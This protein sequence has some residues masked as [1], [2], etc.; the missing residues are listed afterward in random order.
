[1]RNAFPCT[2]VPVIRSFGSFDGSTVDVLEDGSAVRHGVTG[3]M[4][5]TGVGG[6][7]VRY[8]S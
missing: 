3:S 5:L 8:L 6:V 2:I 7:F 1:M 4:L